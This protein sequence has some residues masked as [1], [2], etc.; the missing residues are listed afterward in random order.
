MKDSPLVSI[1]INNYN[2]EKFLPEAINSAL[3][4][5]YK[6]IEVIVVDDGSTD[7]SRDIIKSYGTRITPIF[8]ENGKQG[9]ALNSGFSASHGNIIIF[10][11][12]D[13]YLYASAIERIVDKWVPELGKVHFRLQAVNRS[14]ASLG[15]TIPSAGLTLSSGNVCQKLLRTSSYVSVPM[16]GN[17][18]SRLTLEKVIPIPT[19]YNTTADDYLMISTPFFGS[20][21]AI[22][23]CLGAYR[24]HGSNQWALHKVTGGRFRRFVQHD[25]QNFALL[26]QRANTFGLEVPEELERRSL[27]RIWSRLASLRLEPEEHPVTSDSVPELVGW[28]ISTLWKYSNHN[29]PKRLIYTFLFAWVGFTPVPLA[30]TGLTW[31]YAPHLR[32]RAVDRALTTL[33]EWMS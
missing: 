25:L 1:L 33:R 28:G 10:L 8:Q 18:Y 17:A 14:R 7:D 32:P 11:D 12:A 19:E 16:S 31:L 30:R 3:D 26:R 24:V 27:G 5:T 23:D 2:Y 4:Q 29:L 9:A 21:G 22:N 15:Y 6:H 13:D 20:I